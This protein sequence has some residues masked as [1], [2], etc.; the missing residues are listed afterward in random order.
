MHKGKVEMHA[1]SWLESFK[2]MKGVGWSII[3]IM[4]LQ[5]Q[6]VYYIHLHQ[7]RVEWHWFDSR[8]SDKKNNQIHSGL[9]C[10]RSWVQDCLHVVLYVSMWF[11]SLC[12]DHQAPSQFGAWVILKR[13]VF[14]PKIFLTVNHPAIFHV[15]KRFFTL[16]PRNITPLAAYQNQH[17]STIWF[18]QI[19]L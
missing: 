16:W 13:P 6:F 17:S 3:L 11:N 4:N 7:D 1:K 15:R 9:L 8:R 12:R 18:I 2:G 5:K 19:L 14:I 10:Q